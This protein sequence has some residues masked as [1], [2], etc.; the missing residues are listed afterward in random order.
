[1]GIRRWDIIGIYVLHI[2]HYCNRAEFIDSWI[3]DDYHRSVTNG[4]NGDYLRH[5]LLGAEYYHLGKTQN[6]WHNNDRM[7]MQLNIFP[8]GGTKM[9]RSIT[10]PRV[11]GYI[12]Q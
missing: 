1:M 2:L 7:D 6:G 8:L 4:Y 3:A 12:K 10:K 11:Y 5:K 9:N